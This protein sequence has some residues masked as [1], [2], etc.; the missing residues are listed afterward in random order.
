MGQVF[1]ADGPI[2]ELS[3]VALR[4]VVDVKIAITRRHRVSGNLSAP[5]SRKD[6]RDLRNTLRDFSLGPALLFDA[7]V[8]VDAAMHRVG[9][10]L[11]A[12][13]NGADYYLD[14]SASDRN[15]RGKFFAIEVIAALGQ[16]I[17]TAPYFWD[18][19]NSSVV[20][21]L[22]DERRRAEDEGR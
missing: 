13:V 22:P 10:V 15:E 6:V 11:Q 16:G 14:L 1:F 2:V 9:P 12:L 4:F 18:R 19:E 20:I 17:R 8:D 5:D 21:R 7:L 3:P